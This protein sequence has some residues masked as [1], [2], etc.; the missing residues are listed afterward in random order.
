MAG[1]SNNRQQL[2]SRILLGAVVL[3]L[4]GGMLLYLVPS[5]P[6]T[7]D[8][9]SIDTVAKVGDESVTTDEVRQQLSE[10]EQRNQV[11]KQLESLYAQQI[12]KQLVFQKEVEYE[13]KRLGIHVSDQERADRIRQFLPTAYNGDTF[14]GLDRYAAEVQSR[15]QMTVPVFEEQIRQG[16]LLEKFRKMV[17][18]GIS[19]G[20]GE[21]QDEFRYRNEKLKLNY[22]LI[23]PE[24]LA[25]KINPDDA[26]I[27]ATYEKNKSKY[28]VPEKRVVRYALADVNQIRQNTQVSDA[29]I[30][31]QYQQD[32]QQYQVP[33]RVHVDHILLMTVGKTPAEVE[34]I[35]QKAEDVLKQANKKGAN[36]EDLAK[37]YSED[38]GTKDKG[39]DLGWITQGQTVPEFEKVA[40]S[41]PKGSVSDLVKTQYGFHIIKILDKETAHTKT[42]DEV[43]DSIRSPLMLAKA[44]RQAADIAD[45]LS[46]A[47]R[48]SNKMSLDELAKQFHLSVGETRPVSATEPILELGNSK[49]VKDAIF[50]QRPDDVS[51]PIR[52]DRGYL[53]VAVRGILPAHQGTLDEV[54]DR[55]IAELKQQK[56]T[57]IARQR[58]DDLDK[59]LKSGEKF[60]T[61][62]KTLGLD[63]KTSDLFA[64]NGSI[65]GAASGKQLSAAFQMKPGD[66][67]PPLSLGTSWFVYRVLEKQVPNP[68]DFEKQKK[69]L[70]DQVLQ[71]KRNVAFEAFRTSLDARL[72][73]EGKLRIM[74][75]KLKGFG[76]L[77]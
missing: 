8:A 1:S 13:A 74:T 51:L 56:S 18:D 68:A 7:G 14:V 4:A 66:V 12:L 49:E 41:L 28:M 32:I 2:F 21:L 42:F 70:S 24:D 22:V 65:T 5:M 11:P 17:T 3:V 67:G 40:F 59:H 75:D 29:E 15:F 10:I 63:P 57:E 50:G 36:F 34:E 30:K 6:G 23:K 44:D 47:I 64:R 43:K 16:L 33:N 48:Q 73:Q 31:V 27:R 76:N 26:E 53:I 77:S 19:V 39:G 52:T 38:P 55:V 61:A 20:P 71:T 35:H 58:A 62:A 45:K 9:A 46:A 60:E 25:A 37:K 72:K 54:R 69:D